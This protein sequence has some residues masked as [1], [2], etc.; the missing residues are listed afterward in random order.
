M[1]I[2]IY[3]YVHT[4]TRTYKCTYRGDGTQSATS[5]CTVWGG[6]SPL[7]IEQESELERKAREML[8]NLAGKSVDEWHSSPA[9]TMCVCVCVCVCVCLCVR[10]SLSL[11]LSLCLL[12][13]S[14]CLSV[15][16]SLSLS[17]SQVSKVVFK[18]QKAKFST[19]VMF[20]SK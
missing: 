16:L 6:T 11:S 15:S 12:S 18:S 19:S 20:Y 17:L 1:H 5:A 3:T 8:H 9:T 4:H 14:V 7:E 2:C 13:P 10:L